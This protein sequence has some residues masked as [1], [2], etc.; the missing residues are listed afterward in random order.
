MSTMLK[1][2]KES[3]TPQRENESFDPEF[4]ESNSAPS[5]PDRLRADRM[6]VTWTMVGL[7][8]VIALL[9]WLAAIS[10]PPANAPYLIMP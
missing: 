6:I 7:V 5:S 2:P 4:N 10:P 8:A 1:T 3:M 9:I